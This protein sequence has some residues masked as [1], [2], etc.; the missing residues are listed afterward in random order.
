MKSSTTMAIMVS[1][2]AASASAAATP[3][4]R[5]Q[6]QADTCILDT[7]GN[8]SALDAESAINQWFSD[9]SNVNNFLNGVHDIVDDPASLLAA[10]QTT[11]LSAQDEPCQFKTLTNNPDFSGGVTAAFDCAVADLGNVFG[12]HVLTNLQNIIA[13]PSDTAGAVAAV[14]DINTFRC[15]NVLPD[16]DLIWLDSADDNGISNVVP[17]TAPRPDACASIDCSTVS[18]A[19]NCRSLDNGASG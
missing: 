4:S 9:V 16:A 13:D 1:L 12:P 10:A 3:R 19:A 15:C 5:L 11:L 14:A 8:P 17:I 6:R 7:V 2:A 18:T